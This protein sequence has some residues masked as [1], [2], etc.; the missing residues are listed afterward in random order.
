MWLGRSDTRTHALFWYLT[1]TEYGNSSRRR[2]STRGHSLEA[3]CLYF[4]E[5]LWQPAAIC[6]GGW[7]CLQHRRIWY[8]HEAIVKMELPPLTL[9]TFGG[10]H[11]MH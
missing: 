3:C 2:S 8:P 6:I 7:S 1:L 10:V 5:V 11:L 4:G 9:E